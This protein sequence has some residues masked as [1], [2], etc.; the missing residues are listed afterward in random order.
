MKRETGATLLIN[1]GLLL[2]AGVAQAAEQAPKI[3]KPLVSIDTGFKSSATAVALSADNQHVVAQSTIDNMLAIWKV[4][5]AK[6]IASV[7]QKQDFVLPVD[8][9]P[10]GKSLAH[11][12]NFTVVIRELPGGKE[13]RSLP[14]GDFLEY[15]HSVAYAP[16]GG[17]LVVSS[18]QRLLGFQLASSEVAFEHKTAGAEITDMSHVFDDGKHVATGHADGTLRV[19]DLATGKSRLLDSQI[20][21]KITTVTVSPDGKRLAAV[22][23]YGN[24]EVYQLATGKRE[25]ALDAPGGWKPAVFLHDNV[26]LVYADGEDPRV[27]REKLDRYQII[28][29]NV[30]RAERTHVLRG[31]TA[32]CAFGICVSPDGKRLATVSEDQTIKI[33]D[34]EKL[35]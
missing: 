15:F 25:K 20:K 2:Y 35:R 13:I 30:E 4:A 23:L 14:R 8:I 19:W 10:D 33:W 1:I 21:E 11:A 17:L 28:I 6:R 29:E 32:E 31:H 9:A 12:T 22:P 34:L 7:A 26:S 16:R 24:I 5:T 3:V 27:E 18:E